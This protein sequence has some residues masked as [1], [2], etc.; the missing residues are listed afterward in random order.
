MEEHAETFGNSSGGR[1][2]TGKAFKRPSESIIPYRLVI[3]WTTLMTSE[4]RQNVFPP[5]LTGLGNR[6]S[7]I[8][9]HQVDWPTG[10]IFRQSLILSNRSSA[11]KIVPSFMRSPYNMY[12]VQK[13]TGV[14]TADK[15]TSDQTN[16]RAFF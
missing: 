6:P 14:L 2:V 3:P 10:I 12:I 9:A 5:I 16:C 15:I 7:L 13:L 8:P 1:H 4:Y 11:A